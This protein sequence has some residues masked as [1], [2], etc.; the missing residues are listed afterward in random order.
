[1][2][3]KIAMAALALAACGGT[4][5]QDPQPQPQ[6]AFQAPQKPP[7]LRFDQPAYTGYYSA[8]GAAQVPV[9]LTIV[10]GSKPLPASLAYVLVEGQNVWVDPAAPFVSVGTGYGV[11]W[12]RHGYPLNPG[13]AN[14][15]FAQSYGSPLVACSAI[16]CTVNLDLSCAPEMIGGNGQV[17]GQ[18]VTRAL[19]VSVRAFDFG[20]AATQVTAT[21]TLVC[22]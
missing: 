13:P 3:T 10:P 9:T 19:T 14:Y 8:N 6:P 22:R 2:K 5:Q 18:P 4:A 20:D 7:T 17:Y 15:N 11:A 12:I 16:G 1:M 21:A